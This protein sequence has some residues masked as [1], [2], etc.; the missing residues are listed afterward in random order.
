MLTKLTSQFMGS[1]TVAEQ[2]EFLDYV[3]PWLEEAPFIERYAAQGWSFP[4][5]QSFPGLTLLF[6]QETLPGH[7]WTRLERY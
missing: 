1:G 4:P 6:S 5:S 7:L 3:I 2:Q